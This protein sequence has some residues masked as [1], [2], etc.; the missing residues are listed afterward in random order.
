MVRDSILGC[1]ALPTCMAVLTWAR[2]LD[3]TGI[4][5]T[6]FQDREQKAADPQAAAADAKAGLRY[7]LVWR[8][9]DTGVPAVMAHTLIMQELQSAAGETA[10]DWEKSEAYV[11]SLLEPVTQPPCIYV[12]NWKA[13]DLVVWDNFCSAFSHIVCV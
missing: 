7:P 11:A 4:N 3:W 6:A 13:R 1:H 5:L 12:H 9:P 8:H 2:F 10:M